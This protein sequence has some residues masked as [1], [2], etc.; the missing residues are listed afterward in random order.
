MQVATMQVTTCIANTNISFT[1]TVTH[2]NMLVKFYYQVFYH[3][4]QILKRSLDDLESIKI[5]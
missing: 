5:K 4:L 1:K 3:I 2:S